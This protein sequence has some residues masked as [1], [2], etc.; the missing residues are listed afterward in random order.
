MTTLLKEMRIAQLSSQN[1]RTLIMTH[2]QLESAYSFLV[3]FFFNNSVPCIPLLLANTKS[4]YTQKKRKIINP[5]NK[6]SLFFP[7]SLFIFLTTN[8][9][10]KHKSLAQLPPCSCSPCLF[11]SPP[12]V[13]QLIVYVQPGVLDSDGGFL[14]PFDP[15]VKIMNRNYHNTI[16]WLGN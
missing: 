13:W 2:S 8:K 9:Q 1:E 11:F 12:C 10:T 6:L 15:K 3:N 5:T 4:K 16:W 14:N 7:P